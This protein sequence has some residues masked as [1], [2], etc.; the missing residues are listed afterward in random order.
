MIDRLEMKESKTVVVGL[1][2]Q[3]GITKSGVMMKLSRCYKREAKEIMI[4][5]DNIVFQT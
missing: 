4:S 2:H 5:C 3:R 1:R